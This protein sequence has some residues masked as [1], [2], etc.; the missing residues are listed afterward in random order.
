MKFGLYLYTC[1][2]KLFCRNDLRVR[3]ASYSVIIKE[4]KLSIYIYT[5]TQNYVHKTN[6]YGEED[7][8]RVDYLK[9]RLTKEILLFSRTNFFKI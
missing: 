4:D 2:Y 3:L 7:D 5:H 9:L 6:E 8:T 1:E